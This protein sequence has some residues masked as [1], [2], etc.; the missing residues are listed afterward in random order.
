V[1]ATREFKDGSKVKYKCTDNLEIKEI[2]G[3]S[4][5][6]GIVDLESRGRLDVDLY[7]CSAEVVDWDKEVKY[8]SPLDEFLKEYAKVRG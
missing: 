7:E 8:D 2:F 4:L 3:L 1:I 5:V 6:P